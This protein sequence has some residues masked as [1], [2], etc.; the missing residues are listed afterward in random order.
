MVLTEF[1]FR[2]VSHGCRLALRETDRKGLHVRPSRC[3]TVEDK[4]TGIGDLVAGKAGVVHRLAG[5]FALVKLSEPPTA[6]RG[7]FD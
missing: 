3:V 4:V 5:R 7:V 2:L 1:S 6:G